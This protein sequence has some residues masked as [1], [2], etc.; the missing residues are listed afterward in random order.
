MTPSLII[1]RSAAQGQISGKWTLSPPDAEDEDTCR[2]L[3][4]A[5]Q[6]T[7]EIEISV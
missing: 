4:Y 3:T 2:D 6:D 1:L 7:A 5:E